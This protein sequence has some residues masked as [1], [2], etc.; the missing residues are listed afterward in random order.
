MAEDLNRDPSSMPERLS[1]PPMAPSVSP[2]QLVSKT[3]MGYEDMTLPQPS[4]ARGFVAAIGLG[5]AAVALFVAVA[6]IVDQRVAALAVLIGLGVALGFTRV[7]RVKGVAIGLVSAFLTAV[8]FC[9][10]VIVTTAGFV[11]EFSA[12]DFGTSLSRAFANADLV[13]DDYLDSPSAYVFASISVLVA[14]VYGAGFAGKKS[15][16]SAL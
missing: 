14:F 5:L 16:A 1:P 12:T 4:F 9:V 15:D 13:L 3:P 8:L 7:G 6:F 2:A 11:S 10:A